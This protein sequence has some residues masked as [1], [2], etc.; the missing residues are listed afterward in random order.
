MAKR[1]ENREIKRLEW[2]IPKYMTDIPV[3][4][5]P[6]F[7]K[8]GDAH[9]KISADDAFALLSERGI[10]PNLGALINPLRFFQLKEAKRWRG[11]ICHELWEQGIIDGSIPYWT[12]LGGEDA[13]DILPRHVVDFMKKEMFKGMDAENIETI[14][15][16]VLKY[17]KREAE[18]TEKMKE[19]NYQIPIEREI[20][21][22]ELE[23]IT[24]EDIRHLDE[25]DKVEKEFVE[26]IDGVKRYKI[27]N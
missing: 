7:L 15:Q 26:E 22:R 14:Y 1:K 12:L 4:E 18:E 24:D 17:H 16:K 27:K 6:K 25:M 19:E 20:P 2:F 11:I 23:K 9:P 13:N 10:R 5:K 8:A 21:L 3:N